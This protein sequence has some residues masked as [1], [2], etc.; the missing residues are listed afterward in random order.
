VEVD[1]LSGELATGSCP[2]VRS[3]VFISGTQPQHLCHLHGGNRTSI[4]S[5]DE[6][7]KPKPV[8]ASAAATPQEPR[9]TVASRRRPPAPSGPASV[10][11]QK[12]AEPSQEP[13]KGLW[14]RFRDIFR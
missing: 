4:A 11:K 13:K 10:V 3:E 14:G 5:W 6:E 9:A 8:V 12:P 7:E 2:K 1:P